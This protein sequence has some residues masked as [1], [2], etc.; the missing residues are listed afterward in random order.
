L[1]LCYSPLAVQ[2][3]TD[4]FPHADIYKLIGPDLLHQVIK[5]TFK[6]HLVTWVEEYLVLV[7]GLTCAKVMLDDIDRWYV[8]LVCCRGNVVL[9]VILRIR[10]APS[11]PGLRQFPQGCG[12]KQW[13]GDDSKALMKVRAFAVDISIHY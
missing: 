1:R 13:T 10:A 7:H 5:G 2:P 11:F 4:E 3:F 8:F 9:S 12:F 6:D